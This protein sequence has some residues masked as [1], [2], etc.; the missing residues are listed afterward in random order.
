[1]GPTNFGTSV[2]RSICHDGQHRTLYD[3]KP[4]FSII[5]CVIVFVFGVRSEIFQHFL[6]CV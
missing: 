2:E 6:L 1:M 5:H 3:R 4:L